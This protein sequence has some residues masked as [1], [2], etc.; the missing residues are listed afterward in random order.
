MAHLTFDE[1]LLP[2][3]TMP[4]KPHPGSD[5]SPPDTRFGAPPAVVA[6]GAVGVI[7]A[8][9]RPPA[10]RPATTWAAEVDPPIP[11]SVF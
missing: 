7:Y 1:C 5:A 9:P 2:E 6:L 10:S 3:P 8:R 4:D 11:R